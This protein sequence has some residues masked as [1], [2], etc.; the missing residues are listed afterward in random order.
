M[1]YLKHKFDNLYY[2]SYRYYFYV[3]QDNFWMGSGLKS[4]LKKCLELKKN[5][6]EL[7]CAPHT[8]NIYLE[9]LVN[10]GF[11]GFLMFIFFLYF[12]LKKHFFVYSK[13]R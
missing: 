3:F 1:N 6:E 13:Q 4:Y 7:L 5:K 9:I 2:R 11:I 8:H 10:Q 12:I